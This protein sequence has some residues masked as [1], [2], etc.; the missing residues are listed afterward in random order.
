MCPLFWVSTDAELVL[1]T[2]QKGSPCQW[3]G[4]S[5]VFLPPHG[6]HRENSGFGVGVTVTY[7][8]KTQLLLDQLL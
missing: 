1:P 4:A 6:V 8:S 2:S 7:L 3:Y 5:S